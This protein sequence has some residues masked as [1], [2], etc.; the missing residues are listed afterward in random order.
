M[1]A[2][3]IESWLT[4]EAAPQEAKPEILYILPS[5]HGTPDDKQY[6]RRLEAIH[7]FFWALP[8]GEV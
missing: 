4:S 3:F 6:F 1:I 2:E 7:A 5:L 8:I